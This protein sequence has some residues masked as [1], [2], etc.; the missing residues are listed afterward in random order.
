MNTLTTLAR[1]YTPFLDPLDL[2]RQWFLL[3]IP[4]AIL[5]SITWKA[6]RVSSF[7]AFWRPVLIMSAQIVFAMVGLAVGAYILVDII[8]P[9]LG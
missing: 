8:V 4:L 1:A 6:V 2:Q 3:L 5:I 9:M 7:H